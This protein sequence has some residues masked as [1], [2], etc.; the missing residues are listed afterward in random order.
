MARP[1]TLEFRILA[2]TGHDKDVIRPRTGSDQSQAEVRDASGK[3]L[4]WWVPVKPGEEKS[5]ANIQ[6]WFAAPRSRTIAKSGKSSLS[7]TP[8]TS[9]AAT[10]PEVEASVDSTGMPCVEFTLNEAGGKLF[11]KLTGDHLPDRSAGVSY[12]LGVIVDGELDSAPSIQSVISDQGEITGISS[13]DEVAGMW[14][15]R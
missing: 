5:F 1:G 15:R 12:R 14:W 7:R 6:T 8:A 10:L 4:A 9:P 2:G 13:A 11:A 3:R